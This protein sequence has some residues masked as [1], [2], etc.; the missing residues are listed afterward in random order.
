MSV[1]SGMFHVAMEEGRRWRNAKKRG[2]RRMLNQIRKYRKSKV[3]RGQG[4]AGL[5][6]YKKDALPSDSSSTSSSVS[7]REEKG[8]K[9]LVVGCDA[10]SFI[11]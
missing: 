8:K 7:K 1:E 9:P 3:G 10:S 2:C 4:E 11:Q 6:W 5:N